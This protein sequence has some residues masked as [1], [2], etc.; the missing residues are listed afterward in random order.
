MAF[1]DAD[2]NIITSVD[3]DG[4]QHEGGVTI[5]TSD[6]LVGTH[7][8]DSHGQGGHGGVTKIEI[9]DDMDMGDM[10]H[11][12]GKIKGTVVIREQRL[13]FKFPAKI[14]MVLSQI[15]AIIAWVDNSF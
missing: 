6:S 8:L 12:V 14:E 2:G 5:V 13:E 4:R 9:D 11:G 7:F 10:G 1:T 15:L 3:G